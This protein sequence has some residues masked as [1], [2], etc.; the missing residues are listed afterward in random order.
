MQRCASYRV[1]TDKD[2]IEGG[3]GGM[4]RP[5]L[6]PPAQIPA[7]GTT[8]PGSWLGS[9]RQVRTFGY[10]C[11]TRTFGSRSRRATPSG[12]RPTTPRVSTAHRRQGLDISGPPSC[13]GGGST[14]SAISKPREHQAFRP[15]AL[16]YSSATIG[17]TESPRTPAS[18]GRFVMAFPFRCER[19]PR[20]FRSM[21]M[22]SV[23]SLLV[24]RVAEL[25]DCSL[26]TVPDIDE[27]VCG[28]GFLEQPTR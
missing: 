25:L 11:M 9:W 2:R 5:C 22:R 27:M 28:A 16:R 17:C 12:R 6:R 21:S 3:S 23:V 26:I 10:G 15:A 14:R 8:A 18:G 1:I 24:I 19:C 13:L 4:D 20:L 7:S